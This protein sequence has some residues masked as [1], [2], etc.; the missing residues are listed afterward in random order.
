MYLMV[1]DNP[2]CGA[3]ERMFADSGDDRGVYRVLLDMPAGGTRWCDVAAVEND[4]RFT[5]A[6]ARQ[7]EDSA[8]GSAWL[9]IG[10]DWGVR[11]RPAGGGAW[12]LDDHGQ[13]GA[14]FLVLDHSDGGIQFSPSKR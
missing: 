3:D 5:E 7:V 14:P 6:H 2:N 9:I 10:G 13:W 4:G 1:E 11:M 8:A 12:S